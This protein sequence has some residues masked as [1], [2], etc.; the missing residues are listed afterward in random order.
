MS[1]ESYGICAYGSDRCCCCCCCCC[2][3]DIPP[4][5]PPPLHPPS[6]APPAA[7]SG[8]RTNCRS[9]HPE[10][11]CN[12]ACLVAR[13]LCPASYS[14]ATCLHREASGRDLYVDFDGGCM[15]HWILAKAVCACVC[16]EGAERGGRHND[17]PS[18]QVTQAERGA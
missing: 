9:P 4:P 17:V 8:R 12:P 14:P 16:V 15:S 10:A 6:E 13:V 7:A 3:R 18:G 1:R 5:F 11:R 2:F